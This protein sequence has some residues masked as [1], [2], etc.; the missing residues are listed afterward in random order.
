[1]S[2]TVFNRLQVIF[3]PSSGHLQAMT[4]QPVIKIEDTLEDGLKTPLPTLFN[5]K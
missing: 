4:L 2:S 3:R 1:V 5:L